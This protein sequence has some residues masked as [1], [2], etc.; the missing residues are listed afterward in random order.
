MKAQDSSKAL[1]NQLQIASP[2]PMLWKDMAR[3][4]E[5]AVR[6][7]GDCR[8]N[9]YDVSKMSAADA[10]QLLQRAQITGESR[11]MQLY[12]RADGTIITDDCPVGLKRIRDQWRKLKSSV[13][14]A[15]A[16]TFGYFSMSALA[17]EN[18]PTLGKV[19]VPQPALGEP[20]LQTPPVAPLGGVPATCNWQDSAM[21]APNVKALADKIAA[22]GADGGKTTA[23][24][25]STM[26][27]RL[28][29][30]R[31]A[32][33]QNV[34]AWAFDQ[35]KKLKVDIENLPMKNDRRLEVVRKDLLKA[36]I[37]S[38]ISVGKKLNLPDD[39]ALQSELDSLK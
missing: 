29:M 5:E 15:F 22:R 27:M 2:C 7:Y 17:Q 14:A 6:F 1:F 32:N 21:K 28:E 18:Q 30:A 23:D 36:T 24:K 38:M 16:F 26:R 10:N 39:K 3:T 33:D 4:P 12:R 37:Q 19:A 11:C 9:V 31:A 35:M 20:A 8:K 34:A 13:T 25:L